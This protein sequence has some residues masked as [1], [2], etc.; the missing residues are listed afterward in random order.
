MPWVE[1]TGTRK[2]PRSKGRDM[3]IR[4]VHLATA[5]A[6]A[7]SLVGGLDSGLASAAAT[8]QAPIVN[9]GELM[10]QYENVYTIHFTA[11]DPEGDALTIVT[12]P[13]NDDWI[14]CDAGPPTDFT[15]EYASNRYYDPAPLPTEPFQ[16]TITYSVSD[17]T[18]TTTGTW[19][20]T[21]LPPPI[22][23]V[24][25]RPTVTEGG[26]AVLQLQLSTN[27]FGS[28]VIPAHV[29]TVDTADGEVVSTTSLTINVADGQTSTDIHIPIDDDAIDEPTEYFKVSVDATD[30]IPYRFADGGNLVTVLDNDGAKPT[31]KVPPVVGKHRNIVVERGGARPAWVTYS[32]PG[33]TDAVDGVLPVICNPAPMSAMAA[34]RTQVTCTATDGAG[35]SSSSTFQVTVRS[36]KTDGAAIAIG[37]DRRCVVP[38]QLVWV[39]GEGFTPS[40]TVTIQLQTP[41]LKVVEL[42]TVRAD[43]KGRV[44][45]IVKAPTVIAGDADV[46]LVGP[47]GNDDLVRML[48]VR[49][50]RSHR[51]HGHVVAL[52][53]N[54]S[55]D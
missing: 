42:R 41:D 35:N 6:V 39:E 29:V 20:V 50:G 55:C 15:C 17:G 34:G 45:E 16:R 13:V 52:L 3:N 30:A 53:R 4:F 25:G 1:R 23:T 44:R 27:T 40:A 19:T 28:M 10:V 32:P 38:D 21:V 18:T 33:A 24:V 9:G 7:G 5:F 8:N 47:A 49:I 11:S 54:R 48:P 51:S 22:M 43:R 31:D 14:S 36:P 26:E 2:A 12:P 46:V 37:G